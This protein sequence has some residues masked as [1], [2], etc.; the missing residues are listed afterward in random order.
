MPLAL[1]PASVQPVRAGFIS[2]VLSDNPNGFWILNDA[3]GSP[4]TAADSSGNGFNGVY[5]PGVTPQGIAGPSWVA[6]DVADFTGGTIA[7]TAPLD[8][9]SSGFTIEAWIDPSLSSLTQTTRIVDSGTG[10]GG[11]GFGTASGGG[12]VFT[13]FSRTDYFT[14]DVTLLPNQW[15]YVGVVLDASN[16]ANF[17]VNGSLVETVTGALSTAPSVGNFSF[18]NQPP[19]PGHTDEIY[20]GGAAG[21]SVYKTALTSAQIQAQFDAAG[22]AVPEPGTTVLIGL[23]LL[24]LAFRV[25]YRRMRP[26]L[27]SRQIF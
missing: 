16:D 21:I 19:G 2:E 18:G 11:Y 17:Y 5:G 1:L 8:L 3:P 27:Q 10:F 7:F 22:G 6:S 20:T 13:S 9:G 15:Q 14:T 4:A 24:G 23:S 25:Y 26:P 12:L